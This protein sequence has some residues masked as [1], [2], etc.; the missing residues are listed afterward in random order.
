MLEKHWETQ[1]NNSKSIFIVTNCL[2]L[3]SDT[4]NLIKKLQNKYDN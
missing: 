1:R 4:D 3:Q 2:S